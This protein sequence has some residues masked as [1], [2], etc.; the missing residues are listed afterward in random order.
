M[1]MFPLGAFSICNLKLRNLKE[2]E[3]QL[4]SDNGNKNPGGV[5]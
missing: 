4:V 3:T 2:N 1:N 5:S